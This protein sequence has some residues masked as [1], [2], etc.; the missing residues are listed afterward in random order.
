MTLKL[1]L[2][3]TASELDNRDFDSNDSDSSVSTVKS[4]HDFDNTLVKLHTTY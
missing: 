2:G 1:S 4:L 3:C